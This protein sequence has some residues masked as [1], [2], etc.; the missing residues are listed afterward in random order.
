MMLFFS[1]FGLGLAVVAMPGAV[2]AQA[3]R[4]GL[5]RG[6]YAALWVQIGAL[7]G[8]ALWSGIG[9]MGAALIT[10]NIL[11]RLVLNT[12]GVVLLLG[13]AG[14]ALRDAVRGQPLEA[15]SSSV[16]GDFVLGAVLS[17]VNP[18]PVAFWLGVGSGVI[19]SPAPMEVAIFFLGLLSS[20]MLWSLFL[21]WL[22]DKGKRFIT[23][24]LF[25][26]VSLLCGLALGVFALKLAINVA[27]MA[28][29]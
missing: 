22:S 26:I 19:T 3:V 28:L 13:L 18:L 15:P 10:E 4:N 14:G 9:L 29:G 6:F 5:E 27:V 23:P 1:G 24:L 21:A 7:I 12:A 16:H 20:A 25:R 11:A 8:L 17:L 2:T